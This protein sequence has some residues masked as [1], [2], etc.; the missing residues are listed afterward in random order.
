VSIFD[1][2]RSYKPHEYPGVIQFADAINHSMWLFSE[3]NFLSDIH[4]FKVA[5]SDA[6]RQAVTRTLLAISQI[7][8]DVKRFWAKLGERFPKPEIEE[9]GITFAESE[10]RHARAY[11]HLLEVLGLNGDFGQLLQEP[12]IQG[13]VDYMQ[14][15]LKGAAE[16]SDE[17]YALTLALFAIFIENVSL[18]SQFLV[19]QSFWKKRGILKDVD[20]VVQATRKEE[21]IHALF[22][23]HLIGIIREERPEWFGDEFAAKIRRACKKAHEAEARIIEWIFDAGDLPFLTKAE[24]LEYTKGRF[25]K[26]LALLGLEPLFDVDAGLLEGVAWFDEETDA[27]VSTDFFHKK[28]VTYS[29]KTKPI[30]GGDLF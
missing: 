24:V 19:I 12:V 23:V 18:F 20:N 27:E 1:R 22:G 4:D 30:T 29:K 6:E 3:W 16:S 26:S 5:L 7:E 2:R 10:V 15:Y 13:R 25:N 17:G 11:S 8:V 9:V 21:L 14:K 28:P